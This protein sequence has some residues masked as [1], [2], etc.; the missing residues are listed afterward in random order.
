MEELSIESRGKGIMGRENSLCKVLGR[1]YQP[2]E[3]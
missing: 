3:S 1:M 2:R